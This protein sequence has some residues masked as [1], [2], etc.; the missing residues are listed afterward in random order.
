MTQS[1]Y[2]PSD[3]RA[4]HVDT[5]D[6]WRS[7]SDTD[8]YEMQQLE[9]APYV[10]SAENNPYIQAAQ[11]QRVAQTQATTQP[12]NN[13]QYEPQTQYDYAR[14]PVESPPQQSPYIPNG[15]VAKGSTTQQ[16]A[17]KRPR[18]QRRAKQQDYVAEQAAPQQQAP[19]YNERPVATKQPK[20]PRERK[21]A[22][23]GCLS[24]FLWI[25]ILATCALLSI[26]LI[27]ADAAA[28]QMIP[29][30]T[31]LIPLA[32]IPAALCFVLALLWRRRLLVVVSF[33][34]LAVNVYWHAGYF[35]PT[36]RVS[37]AAENAVLTSAD[38]SDSYAR[39]MTI[40]T[41]AGQAS[42]ADIVRICREQNVEVLCLQE[43]TSSMVEDLVNAG[44]NDVLPYS[45]I[46]DVATSVS[47]GGRNA[48]YTKAPMSNAT[49][50]LLT[51]ETSSMPAVDIQIGDQTVRFVSVHPN[52]PIRGAQ[53]LWDEGLSVIGSLSNYNHSYVVMGDFNSTWDHARF[54]ELLGTTFVD[55]SQQSGEGFHMSYPSNMV[56]PFNGVSIPVPSVIEIDH[57]VYSKNSGIVVSSLETVSIGGT[58]HQALLATLEVQ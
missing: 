1:N 50:N 38:T 7:P 19:V 10:P 51:I 16:P 29:E 42:S 53:D 44:I 11:T 5:D 54:R 56:V 41:L 23:H 6:M 32:L 40:N 22:K 25:I 46:S 27:P 48:I 36:A 26:R 28:G 31:S 58:D 47:N 43:M 37:T 57:I 13:A 20:A 2:N 39:I 15:S 8:I 21:P 30:L 52:S 3:P 14:E 4:N 34:A 24:F 35:I 45:I 12:Q 17:L 33:I 49:G 55:A 9:G 18:A